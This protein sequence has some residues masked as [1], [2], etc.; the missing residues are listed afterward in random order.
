MIAFLSALGA[1]AQIAAATPPQPLLRGEELMVALRS[2]GYT[3]LVRHARTDRSIPTGETPGYTPQLRAD[4]RNL[5]AAGE[6]DVRLMAA[7]VR[8]YA[9]PISEV[10]SSPVYRCR[11]TADAFGS[12]SLTA[13]LRTFPTTPET[14]ALLAA[15][16]RPGTNRVLVTHHFVIELHVPGIR[17]GDIGESEAAV[18]RPA[19]NGR[20]ELVGKILL[21][22][23]EALAGAPATVTATPAPTVRAATPSSTPGIPG[24]R[25]GRLLARYIEAYNSGDTARMRAFTESS[26]VANPERPT[27]V[28][29]QNY[30][31]LFADLGPLTITGTESSVA[32]TVAL[33]AR[34]ARGDL[35]VRLIAAPGPAD[36]AQ[37]VTFRMPGG[38]HP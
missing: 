38:G 7:V 11:E 24:T 3:I 8:K 30:L 12:P 14:A 27:E 37:S 5:T 29:L 32:D 10:L 6:R 13:V 19:G 22:D 34:S 9:W 1:A 4:Q 26:L 21:A 16:P 31:R 2:G 25:A 33:Q 28:R 18:V 15:A 20:V 23:W 35:I 36:R 17:P